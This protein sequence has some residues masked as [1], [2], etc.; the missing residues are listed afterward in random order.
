MKVLVISLFVFANLSL[1]GNTPNSPNQKTLVPDYAAYTVFAEVVLMDN[2]EIPY[3]ECPQL[4][5]EFIAKRGEYK[6]YK[7][8]ACLLCP[9]PSCKLKGDEFHYF[10]YKNGDFHLSVNQCNHRAVYKFF[11]EKVLKY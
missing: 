11:T 6:L 2:L 8:E 5:M 3:A 1:L 7:C 9:V 4:P 10:V